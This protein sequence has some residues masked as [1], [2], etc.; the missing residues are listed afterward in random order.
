[1]KSMSAG[2]RVGEDIQEKDFLRAVLGN[3]Y[4][5]EAGPLVVKELMF[6]DCLNSNYFKKMKLLDDD[7]YDLLKE[8]LQW[9]GS[10]VATLTGGIH[11]TSMHTIITVY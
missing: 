3:S 4:W 6:L 11:I 1:M 9:D 5:R 10:A 8:S 7:T 2:K